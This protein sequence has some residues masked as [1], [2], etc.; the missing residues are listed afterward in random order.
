MKR[1]G[2]NIMR[3]NYTGFFSEKNGIWHGGWRSLF[4]F[5]KDKADKQKENNV[6]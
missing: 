2:I 5:A 4:T 3:R 6:K 1:K